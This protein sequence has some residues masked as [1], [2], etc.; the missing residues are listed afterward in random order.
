MLWVAKNTS[1]SHVRI[2]RNPFNACNKKQ[3]LVCGKYK[4]V[5][6]TVKLDQK[7]GNDP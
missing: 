6:K 4:K 5:G 2:I 1:P 3:M 7:S